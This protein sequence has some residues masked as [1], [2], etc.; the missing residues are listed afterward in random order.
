MNSRYGS[1]FLVKWKSRSTGSSGYS[2]FSFE[3]KAEALD[4][5]RALDVTD[6][7][8][9]HYVQEQSGSGKIVAEHSP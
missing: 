6:S 5:A 9:V 2:S 7:A 8:Y 1:T 4:K 3:Q